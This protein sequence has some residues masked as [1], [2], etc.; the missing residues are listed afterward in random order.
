MDLQ[1]RDEN[2]RRDRAGPI[3]REEVS[4]GVEVRI[5]LDH[6]YR[7]RSLL[8][9]RVSRSGN[10][11]RWLRREDVLVAENHSPEST[12]VKVNIPFSV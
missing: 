9:T 2:L 1:R 7:R 5:A 8:T 4:V 6:V 12:G 11:R 3:I 10:L